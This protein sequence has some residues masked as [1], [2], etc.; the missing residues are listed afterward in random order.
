MEFQFVPI[1]RLIR[2]LLRMG[3]LSSCDTHKILLLIEPGVFGE[4]RDHAKEGLTGAE[5]KAVE[6][7]EEEERDGR[8][9]VKGLLEKK[10]PESVKRQV[11]AALVS[12]NI[13]YAPQ[14]KD[15]SKM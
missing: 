13:I 4:R 12:S 9:I 14:T 1:L 8:A 3:V 2:T 15:F 11:R 5:E 6:A 10:L 7:G